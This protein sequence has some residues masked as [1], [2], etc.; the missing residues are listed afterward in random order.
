MGKGEF[1]EVES[2]L[3]QN[4]LG[5]VLFQEREGKK[6]HVAYV[7]RK[8]KTSEKAYAVIEKECFAFCLGNSEISQ[9]YLWHSF[10]GYKCPPAIELL[11]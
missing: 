5:A 8:L 9:V 6:S 11:E 1:N 3:Q 7:S 10:P 4:A 2:G